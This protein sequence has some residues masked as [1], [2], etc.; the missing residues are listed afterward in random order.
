MDEKTIVKGT[1]FKMNIFLIASIILSLVSFSYSLM[2]YQC[3]QKHYGTRYN[4]L[5]YIV[6]PD[7]CPECMICFYIGIFLILFAFFFKIEINACELSVTN[8]RVCGKTIFGKRVDLPLDKI[9]SVGTSIFKAIAVATSSGVIRFWLLENREEVYQSVSKLLNE[10]QISIVSTPNSD[11]DD[12]KKLKELLDSG[13]ITQEEFDK[14]KKQ[15][16]GL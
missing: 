11:L 12:L 3:V 16:L 5:D 4:F 2:R 10:R 7:V 15:L 8:K 14:K 1:F 6:N 9:S 13:I